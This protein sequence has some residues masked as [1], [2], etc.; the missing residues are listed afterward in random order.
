MLSLYC[1]P[2]FVVVYDSGAV[3]Y[4]RA[5]NTAAYIWSLGE[6]SKQAEQQKDGADCVEINETW[7]NR[8]IYRM[9]TREKFQS[10]IF[11]FHSISF[12]FNF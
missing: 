2:L 10:Q 4:C 8:V 3:S 11:Y 7:N 6:N 5:C 1:V 9:K 12:F